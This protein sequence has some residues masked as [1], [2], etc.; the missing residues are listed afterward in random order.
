MKRMTWT[1]HEDNGT[2]KIIE[3]LLNRYLC[4][5]QNRCSLNKFSIS[6]IIYFSYLQRETIFIFILEIIFPDD[7]IWLTRYD[8]FSWTLVILPVWTGSGCHERFRRDTKKPMISINVIF[9]CIICSVKITVENNNYCI[10]QLY[11]A[12]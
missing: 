2:F 4:S 7:K 1:W 8:A 6:Q 9:I 11:Q 3:S 5:Y 12:T 10:E